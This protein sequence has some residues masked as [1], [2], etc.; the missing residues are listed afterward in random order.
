MKTRIFIIVTLL[1]LVSAAL[2]SAMSPDGNI[3]LWAQNAQTCAIKYICKSPVTKSTYK[4]PKHIVHKSAK[5]KH[6]PAPLPEKSITSVVRSLDD[7]EYRRLIDPTGTGTPN[8]YNN[9]PTSA[10]SFES[11]IRNNNLSRNDMP[12]SCKCTDPFN[13][14]TGSYVGNYYRI[15]DVYVD[16]TIDPGDPSSHSSSS[17]STT[18]SVNVPEPQPL[19]LLCIGLVLLYIVRL[20]HKN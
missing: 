1:L 3:S 7:P 11:Q 4:K 5:P 20:K 14:Y 12:C 17:S 15:I 8:L 19:I 6:I 16:H 18:T 2:A 13:H 9:Y 10:E